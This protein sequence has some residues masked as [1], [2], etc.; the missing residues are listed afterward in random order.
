MVNQSGRILCFMLAV[1]TFCSH[2]VFADDPCADDGGFS[3]LASK[4]PPS[5]WQ[6]KGSFEV[7]ELPDGS[8][9]EI[10][11][12]SRGQILF[13][14]KLMKPQDVVFSIIPL[15][16]SGYAALFSQSIAGNSIVCRNLIYPNAGK[17]IAAASPGWFEDLDRDG[18]LE[19]IINEY[20]SWKNSCNLSS[21]ELRDWPK[22]WRFNPINGTKTDISN[23]FPIFY[24]SLAKDLNGIYSRLN[25]NDSIECRQGFQEMIRRAESMA[26]RPSQIEPTPAK[27]SG[28]KPQKYEFVIT[29]SSGTAIVRDQ[30]S[31]S[32]SVIDRSSYKS[33]RNLWTHFE[34]KAKSGG[35]IRFDDV[36]CQFPLFSVLIQNNSDRTLRLGEVGS[37]SN[38]E[39]AV[40][41]D[42]GRGNKITALRKDELR[43][44]LRS[45]YAKFAQ[46][47]AAN[48]DEAASQLV[49][50]SEVMLQ[51]LPLLTEDVTVLPASKAKFYTCF[52]YVPGAADDEELYEWFA[53][54]NEITL[55]FVDVPVLRDNAGA[56]QKSANYQFIFKIVP[57]GR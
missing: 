42:D 6:E 39:M 11:L 48:P 50:Q 41:I 25:S 7:K 24:A 20:Q 54:R 57:S 26:T 53:G 22:V 49:A 43:Q 56:V 37:G 1:L 52:E 8:G 33:D 21:A 36:A 55:D 27:Q 30:V 46:A 17:F 44:A 47:R 10:L 16:L 31:F 4:I 3:Q 32:V 5:L 2:F 35:K 34:I 12:K 29:D 14:D 45:G 38:D 13:R 15:Q 40:V 9:Y 28:K 23:R 19:L 51:R 18:E